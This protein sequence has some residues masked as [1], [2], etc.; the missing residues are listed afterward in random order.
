MYTPRNTVKPLRIKEYLFQ[1][2]NSIFPVKIIVT[3]TY[4]KRPSQMLWLHE[5]PCF[6]YFLCLLF[7]INFHY[8][9][10]S[11]QLHYFSGSA[12]LE[13]RDKEGCLFLRETSNSL[14]FA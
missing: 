7:Y 1:T 12:I 10:S 14:H 11:S 13:I 8:S 2:R 9:F 6:G 3:V 4:R 5:I